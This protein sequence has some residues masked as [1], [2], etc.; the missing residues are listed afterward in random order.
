MTVSVAVASR[1]CSLLDFFIL[2]D[3]NA[4]STVVAGHTPRPASIN[5]PEGR[6]IAYPVGSGSGF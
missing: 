4:I 1:E 3:G 6:A 5:R 2:D